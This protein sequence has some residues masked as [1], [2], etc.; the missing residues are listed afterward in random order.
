MSSRFSQIGECYTF[1]MTF[2]QLKNTICIIALVLSVV[3]FGVPEVFAQGFGVL[4]PEF[5]ASS[6]YLVVGDKVDIELKVYLSASKLMI[7]DRKARF[8]I[9]NPKTGQKCETT[10]DNFKE[11]GQIKGWCEALSEAGNMEVAVSVDN[12]SGIPH[13]G[14]YVSP[15]IYDTFN[16]MFNDP[17]T[18][19]K[20]ANQAPSSVLILKQN[21]VTAD[22]KWQHP[23]GFVGY[24]EVIY[25]NVPGEY[26]F[27][28]RTESRSVVVDNLDVSKDYYFKVKA[29]SACKTTLYSGLI[30]YSP[31][32]GRFGAA[33]EKPTTL[34]SPSSASTSAKPSTKKTSPVPLASATASASAQPLASPAEPKLPEASSQQQS[35]TKEKLPT[36]ILFIAGGVLILF[37]GVGLFAYMKIRKRSEAR[38]Y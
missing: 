4:K 3:T 10:D 20:D 2:S 1:T 22:I 29:V 34:P 14:I 25:G 36:G 15:L 21:D 6:K 32:T 13:D 7:E 33:S 31:I 19:C 28:Q 27:K 16:L 37:F 38:K 9:R 35:L 17:Q 12:Q 24:Y 8:T 23:D 26:P 11:D 5:K 30:K 18:A